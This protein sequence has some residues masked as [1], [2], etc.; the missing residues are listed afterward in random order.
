MRQLH[1]SMKKK[2][3]SFTSVLGV[4]DK[5]VT[6]KDVTSVLGVS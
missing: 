6:D 5:D 3:A 1:S 2:M 4:C